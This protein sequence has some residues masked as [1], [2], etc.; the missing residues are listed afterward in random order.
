MG[1]GGQTMTAAETISERNYAFFQAY[2]K[3]EVEMKCYDCKKF[4][5]YG[6]TCRGVCVKE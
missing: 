4:G 5:F 1:K 6:K 2:S 3:K